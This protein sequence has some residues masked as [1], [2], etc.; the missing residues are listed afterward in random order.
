MRIN[1][2]FLSLLLMLLRLPPLRIG[3][4]QGLA[5]AMI[6]PSPIQQTIE[7]AETETESSGLT[8]W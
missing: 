4:G 2:G 1:L 8:W 5:L 7:L 6:L 3:L